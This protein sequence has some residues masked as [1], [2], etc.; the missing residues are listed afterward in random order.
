MR[1]GPFVMVLGVLESRGVAAT[2]AFEIIKKSFLTKK[3]E[4]K[5]FCV[6]FFITLFGQIF[7]RIKYIT[8]FG[9]QKKYKISEVIKNMKTIRECFP[10]NKISDQLQNRYQ[11]WKEIVS[12]NKPIAKAIMDKKYE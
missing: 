1:F 3:W 10:T 11:V 9:F 8:F 7:F 5:T 6:I 12:V 2:F 4:H